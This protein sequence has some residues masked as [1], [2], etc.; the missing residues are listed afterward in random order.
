M[1]S[2]SREE[3]IRGSSESLGNPEVL[4]D[5]VD[6]EDHPILTI[7]EDGEA[8]ASANLQAMYPLHDRRA[9]PSVLVHVH[10]NP[11][12]GPS[13]ATSS[14]HDLSLQ[15]PVE[16]QQSNLPIHSR[17]FYQQ[18]S[19]LESPALSRQSSA[20]SIVDFADSHAL[21]GDAPAGPSVQFDLEHSSLHHSSA[22]TERSQ[23]RGRTITS[24]TPQTITTSPGAGGSRSASASRH[25]FSF[26][27]G[28]GAVSH[29]LREVGHEVK[30][31]VNTG[32]HSPLS[33]RPNH[34]RTGSGSGFAATGTG[35]SIFGGLTPGRGGSRSRTDGRNGSRD[36]PRAESAQ[37][38]ASI[39]SPRDE[40]FVRGSGRG[41]VG[42][43]VSHTS[44]AERP[45]GSASRS[46]TR[47]ESPA[48]IT[49][50]DGTRRRTLARDGGPEL[51]SQDHGELVE[52]RGRDTT[53]NPLGDRD[54]DIGKKRDSYKEFRKGKF[55]IRFIGSIVGD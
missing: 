12:T 53:I 33:D 18:L 24:A 6:P 3:T 34:S 28:L 17:P 50:G 49:H 35:S 38:R 5:E 42:N 29:M 32:L 4:N 26:A 31:V 45:D 13:S 20:R 36:A 14:R 47:R 43:L 21:P 8:T 44:A 1:R 2:P 16:N 23:S 15:G 22:N 25:R 10:S 54:E 41:G 55:R 11:A 52:R 37:G 19:P 40:S 9:D 39:L 27:A 7:P 30:D 46:R 51:E 48:P